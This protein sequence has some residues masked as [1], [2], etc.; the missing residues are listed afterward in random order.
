V[1]RLIQERTKAGLD[2]AR[3]TGRKGGR[4]KIENND[5]KF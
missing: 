5:Q 3:S 1:G 2:A 4:K